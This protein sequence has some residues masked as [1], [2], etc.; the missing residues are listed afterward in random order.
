[1]ASHTYFKEQKAN[2]QIFFFGNQL[3]LLR[4][5]SSVSDLEAVESVSF[6][7]IRIRIG[8]TSGNVINSHTNQ[9]KLK[10]YIFLKRNHLFCLIYVN[11][12][13]KITT[14]KKTS[15]WVWN[16]IQKKLRRTNWNSEGSR[17]R[18]GSGSIKIIRIRNTAY[19]QW[20][21]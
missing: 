15:L 17:T 8:S 12:K 16:L 9:Q 7:Q 19:F 6:G 4:V 13:L 21:V 3:F 14:T 2:L 10:E 1:M 5:L 20:K 18:P 11:N